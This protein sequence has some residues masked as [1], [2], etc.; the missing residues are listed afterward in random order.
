MND[1][2]NNAGDNDQPRTGQPC[3]VVCAGAGGICGRGIAPELKICS[4]CAGRLHSGLT[5]IP[6]L[7]AATD[8]A[9]DREYR[10]GM[11]I[12]RGGKKNGIMLN[13]HVLAARSL[14]LA[15]LTS[16]AGLVIDHR[17]AGAPPREVPGLALFLRGHLDWLAA[18]PAAA[19]L[20]TE[21]DGQVLGLR[22]VLQPPDGRQIRLGTCIMPGCDRWLR[23]RLAAGGGRSP[24]IS[25]EGGAHRW[26]PAQWLMLGELLT[27]QRMSRV[28]AAGA[29]SGTLPTEQAATAAGV[30]A[31]T[32]RK[33]ASR[34]KL[35]RYG[36]PGR[37][38]YDIAELRRLVSARRPGCASGP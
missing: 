6:G 9:L 15:V 23:V 25:C 17:G 7:F 13:E 1:K 27:H 4:R 36:S 3:Q 28:L 26:P 5:S 29:T 20:V 33:W 35:T 22:E 8:D 16:W 12:S 38:E 11:E 32:V 37:A 21:I 18:H 10:P 34:G 31:A 2:I 14:A 24:E 19:D 30:S